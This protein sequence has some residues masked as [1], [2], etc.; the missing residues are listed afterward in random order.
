MGGI[1]S[2]EDGDNCSAQMKDGKKEK[3]LTKKSEE[4]K[5]KEIELEKEREKAEKEKKAA[6]EASSKNKSGRTDQWL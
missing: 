2:M 4:L 1:I 5:A 3:E 6:A